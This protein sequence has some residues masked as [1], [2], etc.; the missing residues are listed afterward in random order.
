MRTAGTLVLVLLVLAG[1]VGLVLATDYGAVLW[2]GVIGPKREA[3]RRDVFRETRSYNEGKEQE[4]TKYRYEYLTA[5]DEQDRR[6]IASTVRNAFADYPEDRLGTAEL[7]TFLRQIK[8][9]MLP[10]VE[11]KGD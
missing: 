10:P 6:A 9:G 3:V 2:Y 1:V 11:M 4:L 5:R 8:V 7:R